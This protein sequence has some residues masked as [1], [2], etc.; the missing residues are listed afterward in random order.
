MAVL[1][2]YP[3]R[4]PTS[5]GAA[6]GDEGAYRKALFKTGGAS[7]LSAANRFYARGALTGRAPSF[8]RAVCE[9]SGAKRGAEWVGL[10]VDTIL[11]V[12]ACGAETGFFAALKTHF[13]NKAPT[14]HTNPHPHTKTHPLLE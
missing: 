10:A 13:S 6:S 9:R 1:F 8:C 12:P 2:A 14:P 5:A 4:A 3:C 7:I 11:L